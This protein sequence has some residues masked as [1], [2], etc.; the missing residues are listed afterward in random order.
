MI[1]DYADGKPRWFF[2]SRHLH[3]EL[4]Q[5][6]IADCD[7]LRNIGECETDLF[8]IRSFP[9]SRRNFFFAD[10]VQGN[11][12][13]RDRCMLRIHFEGQCL[14]EYKRNT[15]VCD[16]LFILIEPEAIGNS[17]AG[18][19]NNPIRGDLDRNVQTLRKGTDRLCNAGSKHCAAAKQ[20]GQFFQ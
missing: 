8:P 3:G 17:I 6:D 14:V 1:A 4:N 5:I 11:L 13:D 20:S 7:N 16:T 10:F 9:D 19:G 15:A 12:V 2:D 18:I